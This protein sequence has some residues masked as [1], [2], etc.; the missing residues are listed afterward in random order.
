MLF[1][2]RRPPATTELISDKTEP[3]GA[4]CHTEHCS[5]NYVEHT[6]I[7]IFVFFLN[8]YFPYSPY[9]NVIG[10]FINQKKLKNYHI[11]VPTIGNNLN[12]QHYC[13]CKLQFTNTK[14]FHFVRNMTY[15]IINS[16][17]LCL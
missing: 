3:L 11:H 2:Q 4:R 7:V 17:T 5:R 10:S 8:H 1:R 15:S 9:F 14:P 16:K 6:K 12:V 13:A